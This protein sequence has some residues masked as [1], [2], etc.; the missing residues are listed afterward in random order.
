[1]RRETS[2]PFDG[3]LV[4]M[5]RRR[6]NEMPNRIA[7]TFLGNGERPEATLTFS[8]LDCKA[9]VIATELQ[10]RRARGARCLLL[11]PPG[12]DYIAAFFGSLYAGAIAV[13]AYPPDPVR[14][15][16]TMPRLLSIA[17]DAQA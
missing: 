3:S 13:P 9:R 7:F 17:R 4:A 12:L 10:Q 2:F 15:E 14:M 8:E 1:M 5:L 6:A 16:R 11:Y